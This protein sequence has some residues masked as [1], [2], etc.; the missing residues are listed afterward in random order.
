MRRAPIM[1]S[2]FNIFPTLPSTMWFLSVMTLCLLLS[3]RVYNSDSQVNNIEVDLQQRI[4]DFWI[5]YWQ[6]CSNIRRFEKSKSNQQEEK[7]LEEMKPFTLLPV[8]ISL[9][10]MGSSEA[11]FDFSKYKQNLL[12]GRFGSKLAHMI[13]VSFC[14]LRIVNFYQTNHLFDW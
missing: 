1:I 4:N 5:N 11:S 13:S 6:T 7:D 3:V 12:T 9:I 8:L 14:K 2:S 10:L